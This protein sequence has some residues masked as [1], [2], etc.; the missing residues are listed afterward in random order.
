MDLINNKVF[1]EHDTGMH[2]EN[3]KRLISF[4][5]LKEKKVSDGS[6]FLTLIH[7]NKYIEI[8][9]K[10]CS[11]S[12]PLDNDTLTSPG[13]YESALRAVGAS[14]DASENGDF[15]I[16]RPPGHHAYPDYGSGFCLFNN[17]A[18][19][20]QKL[21]NEGKRVLIFDFDGHF[22][23]GTSNVFYKSWDVLYWSIHQYP[24]FP[25]QGFVNEIGEGEGKGFNINVPL[26]PGSGD[27]IFMHAFNS[28]LSI[29]KQF[30]PDVVAISAGFDAHKYDPI[31]NLMLTKNS[32]YSIGKVLGENFIHLFATLEGGYNIEELPDCI[33]S[34]IDGVNGKEHQY[35]EEYSSS[36]SSIW[37]EYERRLSDLFIYLK[38]YWVV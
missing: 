8:V 6:D 3:K 2:P 32:Y 20:T 26:P 5:E 33:Y 35:K 19:A 37:N 18:I 27:D 11:R 9:K 36:H 24:A 16:V 38:P 22:G 10:A 14:I 21:V 1:L 25:N 4:G 31:L 28:I 13:T 23:D 30:N 12:F 7:S 15:A 29:A 17:I 34:F